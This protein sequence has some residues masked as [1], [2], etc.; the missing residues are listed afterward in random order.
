[1]DLCGTAETMA[2]EL[3]TDRKVDTKLK[4]TVEER[5][6]PPQLGLDAPAKPAVR[7]QT[8]NVESNW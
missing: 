2:A 7:V 5:T 8:P 1:M 6:I 4:K 3:S